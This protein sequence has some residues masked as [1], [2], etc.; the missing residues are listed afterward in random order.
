MSIG[1][2]IEKKLAAFA[3]C[4]TD[5]GTLW[6]PSF[7]AADD[8]SC[9]LLETWLAE[10][11]MEIYRDALGNLFGRIPGRESRVVMVGSH[12][13]SVKN[14]GRYDGA[15]GLIIAMLAA[16]E[17]YRELGAPQKTVEVVALQEEE[18][19]QFLSGFLG[20]KAITGLLT[21]RALDLRDRQGTRLEAFLSGADFR[22]AV[23][24]DIDLFLELHIEQGPYL[25]QENL[26]LGVVETIVGLIIARVTVT[27]QQNH[28]GT[29]PM[30]LRRD[31]VRGAT[32]MITALLQG[33]AA[34]SPKVTMTFG[35]LSAAPGASNVIPQTVCFSVD[36]RDVDAAN[37]DAL[38]RLIQENLTALETKGYGAA[39][40]YRCIEQPKE[41]SKD[42][43]D[44]I[45]KSADQLEIP[46][47]RM[48]SGAGHDAQIMATRFPAGM[49]FV[50]SRSGISHS[51][52][53]YT[54]PAN[55]ATGFAVLKQALRNAAWQR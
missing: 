43:V 23:R 28:A 15:A 50:P 37:L 7:S 49:L 48:S 32:E 29:T 11:N 19:S 20:S 38:N 12:R 3:A 44:L 53:E 39:I 51:P 14:G 9:A 34:I 40:E 42:A 31:P 10:E 46:Y 36:C 4:A 13:D 45:A 5:G 18:G 1:E 2:K 52:D 16:G 21:E 47:T 17:L 35:E 25:E 30:H 6:R 24:D 22:Q 26:P 54:S 55:L 33:A 27:G 8:R 41:L